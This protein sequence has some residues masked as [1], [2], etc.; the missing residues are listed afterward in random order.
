VILGCTEIPLLLRPQESA[1][2]LVD[3]TRVHAEAALEYAL[4]S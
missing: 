1:L 4:V 3:T 2:P